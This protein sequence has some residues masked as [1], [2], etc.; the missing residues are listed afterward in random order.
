MD[1]QI[2]YA[3]Q[4]LA[5]RL[6]SYNGSLQQDAQQFII[7]KRRF[8]D[9]KTAWYNNRTTA[10]KDAIKQYATRLS[11]PDGNR[12][13]GLSSNTLAT[14]WKINLWREEF[15]LNENPQEGSG[16]R[17]YKRKTRKRRRRK[18]GTK[19]RRRKKKTKRKKRKT[20]KKKKTRR[21]RAG[22]YMGDDVECWDKEPWSP[23]KDEH[24]L[25]S[26][27]NRKVLNIASV[28]TMIDGKK[29]M[30]VM[31][32]R[33]VVGRRPLIYILMDEDNGNHPCVLLDQ[34][35]EAAGI[36][37]KMGN[38]IKVDACSGHYLP[39]H[40]KT[41]PKVSQYL[42]DEG[43]ID[44]TKGSF[45]KE[46]SEGCGDKDVNKD[47][48]IMFYLNRSIFEEKVPE[49]PS[50]A[51]AAAPAASAPAAPVQESNN[52]AEEKGPEIEILDE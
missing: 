26:Y 17:K 29:Y 3:I 6:N 48:E 36:I 21:K 2:E 27:K 42:L 9:F 22:Y 50:A 43:I 39:R 10:R 52:N 18:K 13:M 41:L 7:L 40:D 16:R 44:T 32:C 35:A 45:R 34:P 25:N 46:I 15:E 14:V 5:K 30:Y 47:Y 12:Y 8:R 28:K 38:A 11:D 1:Y 24:L 49:A 23:C 37:I 31:E 33:N 51:A 19:R 4:H 20:R